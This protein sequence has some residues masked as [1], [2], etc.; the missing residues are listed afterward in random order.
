MRATK[1]PHGRANPGAFASSW[2]PAVRFTSDAKAP[3]PAGPAMYERAA[4]GIFFFGNKAQR[5]EPFRKK[6]CQLRVRALV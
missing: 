4:G 5:S 1:P 2:L 6:R 3:T